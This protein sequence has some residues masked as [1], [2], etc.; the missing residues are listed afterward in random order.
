MPV[1]GLVVTLRED[2]SAEAEALD[3][4][5]RL[6]QVSLGERAG[7]ALPLVTDTAS[8]EE[9]EALQRTLAELP[10]VALVHLV[11]ADFSADTEDEHG[12]T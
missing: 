2:P 7:C 11:L 12:T 3:T 10:G 8:A 1:S 6:A 5:R 4:L 9:A